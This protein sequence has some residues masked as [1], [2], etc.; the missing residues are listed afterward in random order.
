M[1]KALRSR[2]AVATVAGLSLMG[3]LAGCAASATASTGSSSSDSLASDTASTY[4]DGTYSADG[5]YNT[6]G[7]QATISVSLTVEDGVV[8]AVTTEAG[9]GDP[10]GE[11]YQ[12]QFDS[13]VSAVVVGKKLSTLDV[14]RVGGSSLTSQG[15][16]SAVSTIRA[17]AAR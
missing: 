16:N 2:T 1:L 5:S 13:G 6:P 4:K 7:G 12:A 9:S 3:L 11:Q 8:T 15:F 10:S 17:D 14:S